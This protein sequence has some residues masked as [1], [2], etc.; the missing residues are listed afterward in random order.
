[1]SDSRHSPL[2]IFLTIVWFAP[3]FGLVTIFFGTLAMIASLFDGHGGVQHRIAQVWAKTLMFIACSPTDIVGPGTLTHPKNHAKTTNTPA[4]NQ[5]KAAIYAANHLSYTDTPVLFSHLP[6]QFRIVARS[7]L[8]KVP[9]IGWYLHRSGQIPVDST[10]LRSSLASMNG[11]AKALAAG[12]PL[13]IFPEGGRSETGQLQPFMNGPA[14][15]AVK[16]G[17]PIVPLALIGTRELLPMHSKYLHPQRLK[18]AVGKPIDTAGFTTR[19]LNPLTE[20]LFA[21]IEDLQRRHGA[22]AAEILQTERAQNVE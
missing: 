19:N 22:P 5:P 3:M 20:Q 14:Y 16:A 2:W 1:M 9:F 17:V 15:M 4:E 10:S 8:W 21:A 7:G 6:F 11:G 13:V 18:L 12:T